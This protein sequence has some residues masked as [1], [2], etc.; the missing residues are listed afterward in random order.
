MT[1]L[2]PRGIDAHEAPETFVSAMAGAATQVSVVT[3][4][5]TEGRFGVTVSAFS[6]VSAEPPLVLV[7]INRRSPAIAA[8]RSDQQRLL[9]AA[10]YRAA[11]DQ[12]GLYICQPFAGREYALPSVQALSWLRP[13]SKLHCLLDDAQRL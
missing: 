10:R 13:T 1:Y 9:C 12:N 5:G 8:L 6:S 4:D 2:N 11:G 7:C 3:T